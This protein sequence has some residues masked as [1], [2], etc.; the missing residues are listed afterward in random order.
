MAG[1][2]LV[3]GDSPMA[4]RSCGDVIVDDEPIAG[5]YASK[6]PTDLEENTEEHTAMAYDPQ[7]II[8]SSGSEVA[9]I[10]LKSG[11]VILV[12]WVY[13]GWL[14]RRSTV[15]QECPTLPMA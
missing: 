7:A 9:D 1:G 11:F 2:D 14:F 13:S 3:F 12:K 6:D 15:V 5:R 10:S 8:E 4:V